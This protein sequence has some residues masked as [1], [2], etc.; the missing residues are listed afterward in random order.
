MALVLLG[1]CKNLKL[2]TG[3]KQPLLYGIFGTIKY[4]GD[5][6]ISH[7]VAK[8]QLDDRSLLWLKHGECTT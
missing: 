3:I 5:V 6:L 2:F 1:F 7:T 4:S 8:S